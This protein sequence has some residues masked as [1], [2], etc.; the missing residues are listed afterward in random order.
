MEEVNLGRASARRPPGP[1]PLPPRD[2]QSLVEGAQ[3]LDIRMELG[4][5][6]AHVPGAQNIWLQGLAS[7]AGW[8]LTYEKP[9]LLVTETSDP[10]EPADILGRLGFDNIA[11]YLAGGMLAWHMAGLQSSSIETI[12]V[13]RLCDL[14]DAGNSFWILDVRSDKELRRQGAIRGAHHIHVTQ[15][16]DRQSEVPADRRVYI[17]CGS[18]LRSMV[19]A[20]YLQ[21][22]GWKDLAVVLGGMAGWRSRRSP[23]QK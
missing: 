5:G 13:Q 19:A 18:G 9:I 2:F 22:R 4:F 3:V 1:R 7:F 11:G 20:S 16:P 14:L 17:F 23:I 10:Q 21:A 12:T 15:L 6:A 8:F